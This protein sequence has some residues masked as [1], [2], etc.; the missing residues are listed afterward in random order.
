MSKARFVQAVFIRLMPKHQQLNETLAYAENLWDYLSDNGYGD[1]KASE[2]R[3]LKDDFYHKLNARQR[4]YFDK[5]W[6]A[7][8]H[9]YGKQRAAMRWLQ[10]GEKSNDD[11][12]QIIAAAKKESLRDFGTTTRK[13]AEGWLSELR[14]ADYEP[15]K[16]NA[17]N[18]QFMKMNSELNGLKQLYDRSKDPALLPAI[19]KLE[20]QL[21]QLRS[22]NGTPAIP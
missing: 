16:S 12:D 6:L 10:L 18:R 4:H 9:K 3:D 20:Q 1:K 11:Y 7:F 2:P 13:Y 14:F 22:Q 5:F 15:D 19:A 8:G 21:A 17:D